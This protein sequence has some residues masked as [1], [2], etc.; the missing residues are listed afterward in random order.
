M[1]VWE[2]ST[3]LSYFI[4]LQL[5]QSA[6]FVYVDTYNAC[7]YPGMFTYVAT[8]IYIIYFCFSFQKILWKLKL[9]AVILDIFLIRKRINVYLTVPDSSLLL[10]IK[11]TDMY[12]S[13]QADIS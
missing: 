9:H 10:Q 13:R 3:K 5:N 4:K 11:T 2:I 7:I 1:A 6:K 8:H 12:T